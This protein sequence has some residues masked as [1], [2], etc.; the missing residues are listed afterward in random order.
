VALPA[1][2]TEFSQI[3]R[4][5][6][7][8]RLVCAIGLNECVIAQTLAIPATPPHNILRIDIMIDITGF[9]YGYT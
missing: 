8:V 3:F 7:R 5:S 9:G 6:D 1:A 2:L 4:L